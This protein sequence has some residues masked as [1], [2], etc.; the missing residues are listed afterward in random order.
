MELLAVSRAGQWG[1]R[2]PAAR[3]LIPRRQD[4]PRPLGGFSQVQLP[5]RGPPCLLTRAAL[6]APWRLSRRTPQSSWPGLPCRHHAARGL[7]SSPSARSELIALS[8]GDSRSPLWPGGLCEAGQAS[9]RKGCWAWG[10][11]SSEGLREIR[12]SKSSKVGSGAH[13]IQTLLS[14]LP[15]ILWVQSSWEQGLPSALPPTR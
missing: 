6:W 11:R 14:G 12:G 5:E 2:L 7:L 9:Q 4:A 10:P 8:A 1:H 15:N 3:G 13:G